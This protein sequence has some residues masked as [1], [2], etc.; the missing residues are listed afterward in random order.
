MSATTHAQS[1]ASS[2]WAQANG[3]VDKSSVTQTFGPADVG[4][5]NLAGTGFTTR[6]DWGNKHGS[7]KLNL[8]WAAISPRS[9]VMVAI[10]EGATGGPD[11][12]KFIG[13]A[14]FHVNNV[15]PRAGGVDIWIDI[16]WGSDIRI[17]ADYLVVNP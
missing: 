11:G 14:K 5:E 8:N 15:A 3:S 2:P 9:I 10:G 17:Y 7:W 13:S 12:G 6:V 16:D 4:P 1:A